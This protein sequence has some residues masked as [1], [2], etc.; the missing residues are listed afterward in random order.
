MVTK[1]LSSQ[2]PENPAHLT[3]VKRAFISGG[4]TLQIGFALMGSLLLAYIV[5]SVTFKG[6]GKIGWSLVDVAQRLI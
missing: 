6:L 5:F 2:L 4:L 1:Y 3:H